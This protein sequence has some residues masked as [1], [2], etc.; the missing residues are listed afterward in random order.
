MR[1]NILPKLTCSSGRFTFFNSSISSLGIRGARGTRNLH[2]RCR[3]KLENKT[4]GR[5]FFTSLPKTIRVWKRHRSHHPVTM[6]NELNVILDGF[7]SPPY[8][9][10]MLNVSM[11]NENTVCRDGDKLHFH[12]IRHHPLYVYQ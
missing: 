7:F 12:E 5:Y 4:K 3:R 11:S 6:G 8:S 10:V 9:T 1:S 2:L